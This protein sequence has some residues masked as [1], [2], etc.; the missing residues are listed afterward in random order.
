ML[1]TGNKG[2]SS[3][4]NYYYKQIAIEHGL[5][6]S[7][8]TSILRD[9]KGVLW[10]GTRSG[11][12]CFDQHEL[13]TF[14]N[15]KDKE[16]SLPSNHILFVAEDSLKNIWVSTNKGVV[17][18]NPEN[19]SFDLVIP[20]KAYA[21]VEYSEGILF[22]GDNA[23][24]KYD[25]K[26]EAYT[27]IF[28][29]QDQKQLTHDKYKIFK[30]QV[31]DD[32]RIMLS[33]KN[34][35]L[36]SYSLDT[37]KIESQPF[38]K[39]STMMASCIDSKGFI[40]CSFFNKGLYY[41]NDSGDLLKF[42]TI[43]NSDLSNNIILD[44]LEKDGQIWLATD[45]GGICILDPVRHTI[46]VLQHIPGDASSLP[47]NSITVLYNDIDNNLWA[48][49]VRGGIFGIKETYIRTYKDVALNNTNGLSE[50][51]IISIYEDDYSILWIGTDGGGINK[52]DP[53]TN[54][55]S[56]FLST[57]GDKVASITDLSKNE[58]LVSL[59][60]KGVFVFNKITGKYSPFIIVDEVV[61]YNE[62]FGGYMPL[63]H[64]IDNDHIL[65]LSEHAYV[66]HPKDKIFIPITTQE[67]DS[68]LGA[69]HLQ[70]TDNK[71]T[72]LSKD[73][74]VFSICLE[75]Y[76]LK[77]L[78][79]IDS[80]EM[81]RSICYDGENIIWIGSDH[82]L[83]S[84]NL[85]TE[86]LQRIDTKM[87]NEISYL[88]LDDRGRLWISAQNMLFSFIINENRLVIWDESD[89]FSPNEILFMYQKPSKTNHIYLA[90]ING[91]VKIDKNISYNASTQ[92]KVGLEDIIL[93][94]RSY[95]SKFNQDERS[96]EVPW[97]YTSLSVA[98]GLSEK[99]VFRQTL[100]RY[101]IAGLSN[102]YIESYNHKLDLS[103]LL[104]GRYSLMASCNTKSGGWSQPVRIVTIQVLSP[105]YK[106][107]WFILL[108][109]LGM[110]G[111]I[112]AIVVVIIRK[113]ENKL[114]WEKKEHEQT[115]NEEK[116][117]FLVNVSHELRTPLTLIYAPLKRLVHKN[118][119]IL[120]TEVVKEQLNI[121]YKQSL[122]M[123]NI[124]NMVLDLNRLNS[125]Y[126]SIQKQPHQLN[127]W[128]KAV[129]EDFR[130]EFNDKNILLIFNL[131]E[132]IGD[133]W[134]DE[135]K[136]QIVL[137]NLLMNALKFS[138][139]ETEITIMTQKHHDCV[140]ISVSDEGIGL[141]NVDIH[142]LFNRFY[143]GQH[144]ANGSG[145][146]L[147]YSKVLIEKHGGS[148][149][150]VN[151]KGK[152][153]TFYFSLP[154]QGLSPQQQTEDMLQI[155]KQDVPLPLE[156]LYKDHLFTSFSL[157]IVED[158]DE[159]R[160]FLKN[161]FKEIFG[162]VYTAEN[163]IEAL[164]QIKQKLPDIIVSDVMMPQMDGYELCKQIKNTIEI[165]H[166][167]V[168]LLTAKCDTDSTEMGY[169]LG[170]D[171]YISKPFDIEFLQLIISNLLKARENIKQ[172]FKNN[173]ALISPVEV[174]ISNAD[175]KFMLQLNKLILNNLSNPKLD[176]MFLTTE[177]AMS[178]ASLY[179]K[180]NALTGLGVNDYIN[181]I[182]IEKAT[183]LLEN[184]NMNINEISFEIGFI[185][186]RYFS[187]IFKQLKGITPSQYRKENQ[188]KEEAV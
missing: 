179:N 107:S 174:T 66:Y 112:S 173:S 48:G 106:T 12:N 49:S 171:F 34:E 162:H 30:L 52:Y 182:R 181:K 95:L 35:G 75:T 153:S 99:D 132:S 7:S 65:I 63:V 92:P 183:D 83:S 88:F 97:N 59:Y 159:L 108:C 125:E 96:I 138:E 178:R 1:T 84:Y 80:N 26:M 188:K 3:N 57:Y 149:G 27:T 169:K 9:H 38:G 134:F 123:K 39:G 17:K 105:W 41:Y 113:K 145:I 10:I 143:Q 148:I 116:I 16:K 136:C 54:Q 170:A 104:P 76:E 147:S 185:Y 155:N 31:L 172:N 21:Y 60:S 53:F 56:H 186:Q 165:S 163:G 90:G 187:T 77:K 110:I 118:I 119:N 24:Y 133:I 152:G 114:K 15:E 44:I 67:D 94:G 168:I 166:I 78:F 85:Q 167:P 28:I 160:T 117:R 22:S 130:N 86:L 40:Y 140:Q 4:Y 2:R 62:C 45:G 156:P 18:Y 82:G 127:T 42:Y 32:K 93:N 142:Q 121:I 111:I 131:D 51:T 71:V 154:L 23:L 151:N 8:I 157:I 25:N 158:K 150:A 176:V 29:D 72:Y 36:F 126:E 55:F 37:D 98:M 144:K 73:N 135:W 141:D 101:S 120:N 50:K 124:I 129:A 79:S 68:F 11:L 122:Q 64:K 184:T 47:V 109:I 103:Q 19:K 164:E 89:G 43:D 128:I 177:M 69:L 175:E 20:H 161:T 46:K 91:L 81:I 61:N 100:Y 13:K 33:T 146:G 58:L 87:F 6:Q 139:P 102:Q 14:L 137:S 115:V 5:T 70:Y 180:M 74:H